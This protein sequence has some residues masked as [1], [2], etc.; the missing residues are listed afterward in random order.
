[1]SFSIESSLPAPTPVYGLRRK[2]ARN[3]GR[4]GRKS[5]WPPRCGDDE[6]LEEGGEHGLWEIRCERDRLAAMDEVLAYLETQESALNHIEAAVEASSGGA[7]FKALNE[8]LRQM[9][10]ETFNGAR[11]LGG[12]AEFLLLGRQC[13]EAFDALKGGRLFIYGGEELEECPAEA[14][15]QDLLMGDI[16]RLRD[17][18]HA[19]QK[20]VHTLREAEECE[21]DI[22]ATS[23]KDSLLDSS[24]HVFR[25]TGE[26]LLAQA[27][28]MN[29]AVLRLLA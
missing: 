24:T 14:S 8:H 19:L 1:M 13:P 21:D 20:K 26:A 12:D 7:G 23:A 27:H 5:A 2:G 29:A 3:G 22:D 17:E 4:S 18:N 10:A 25:D 9:A 15:A 11:L 28:A 16:T 6:S